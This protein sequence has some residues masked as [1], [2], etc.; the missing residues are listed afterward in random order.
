MRRD[1]GL[2]KDMQDFLV[3][4]AASSVG[5]SYGQGYSLK[6]KKE[7]IDRLNLSFLASS[8]ELFMSSFTI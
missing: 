3:G 6:L 1:T 7:D 4:H 5:E 2:A 8:G